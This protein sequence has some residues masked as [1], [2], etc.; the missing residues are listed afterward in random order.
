MADYSII[1]KIEG[2]KG[3]YSSLQE[4]LASPDVISDMKKFVQLNREY[5]ELSPVIE[6]GEKYRKLV[7]EYE[8]AKDIIA[9]EKDDDLR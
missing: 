4:Q 2:L 6:A 8:M 3:K 1:E 9:H 5:K 7:E